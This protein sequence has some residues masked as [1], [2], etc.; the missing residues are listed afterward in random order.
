VTM[1]Y[2]LENTQSEYQ[3]AQQFCTNKTGIYCYTP[4]ACGSTSCMATV[5]ISCP[6]AIF[7]KCREGYVCW[8]QSPVFGARNATSTTSQFE[9][10]RT[11]SPGT[12]LPTQSPVSAIPTGT[13]GNVQCLA[14]IDVLPSGASSPVIMVTNS[15]V[16]FE[17]TT[18]NGGVSTYI[19]TRCRGP[20]PK[21]LE[22]CLSSMTT[23]M[24]TPTPT[25]TLGTTGSVGGAIMTTGAQSALMTSM[26]ITTA[27]ATCDIY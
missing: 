7:L 26:S 2:R 1:A 4:Q 6:E 17:V 27:S 11:S 15:S 19:P 22:D 21:P 8:P 25:F 18:T 13:G 10:G 24:P 3:A 5:M 23:G 14:L 9:S 16:F 20:N 12:I